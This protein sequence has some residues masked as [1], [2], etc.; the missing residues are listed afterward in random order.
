MT[1]NVPPAYSKE[2]PTF[3]DLEKFTGDSGQSGTEKEA[4]LRRDGLLF[5]QLLQVVVAG[6]RCCLWCL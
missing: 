1:D 2:P 4:K 5:Q 3:A 6:A